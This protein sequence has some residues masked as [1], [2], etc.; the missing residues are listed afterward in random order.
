[1]LVIIMYAVPVTVPLENC[2][3]GDEG[4]AGTILIFSDISIERAGASSFAS[5]IVRI[6]IKSRLLPSYP[7]PAEV[8]RFRTGGRT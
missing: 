3:R 5:R 1:M 7:D 6:L 4:D 8:A 2:R